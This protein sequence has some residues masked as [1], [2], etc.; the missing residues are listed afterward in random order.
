MRRSL[1]AA[2]LA[3]T[4]AIALAP[5]GPAE[6]DGPGDES[7]SSQAFSSP[8]S[9]A[10]A[11]AVKDPVEEGI[12]HQELSTSPQSE[13][14]LG[15]IRS[16]LSPTRRQ[17]AR[18]ENPAPGP[19]LESKPSSSSMPRTAIEPAADRGPGDEI[20]HAELDTTPQTGGILGSASG[21]TTAV[22]TLMTAGSD[23][24]VPSP[25]QA[26][27][28]AA[29]KDEPAHLELADVPQKTGI[30]GLYT[31]NVQAQPQETAGPAGPTGAD[32]TA[33][34][35]V[36]LAQASGEEELTHQALATAVSEKD[37]FSF[38]SAGVLVP[39]VDSTFKKFVD[40][41]GM[42]TMGARKRMSD[43]LTLS[44]TVGVGVLSGDWSIK[45]DRQ[46]ILVAAE[47]YYPGYVKE[48]GVV[49]TPEELPDENLGISYHAEA[50]AVVTSS[51]SLE[52]IDVHTD[53]YLFPVSLNAV[54]QVKQS[55]KF[56]AYVTGGLGFCTAVRDCDSK[57]V[58]EKYFQGPEYRVAI[59]RSQSVTGLLV[60]LGAG[61]SMPVYGRLTFVAEA[62]TTLYDLKAFDPVLEVS[63]TRPN[64]DW[65]PGSD[66]SQWSYEDPVRVGVYKEV[67][68]TNIQVG[69]V[70][71]F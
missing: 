7:L 17:E 15:F 46:S 37:T 30:L 45:G 23:V 48:P 56:N 24:R 12:T 9:A 18:L 44:A 43:K 42:V 10:T 63:F 38:V 47:E 11:Q 67:Y 52:R 28:T 33:Q 62:T 41:G 32:G 71:P 50:E 5:A 58:K 61:M 20:V 13:S 53:L 55:P 27:E 16:L 57:A 51:E 6:A 60:N 3:A 26:T 70:V 54:Y 39:L 59:N 36:K 49:I 34:R 68:V 35:G 22:E 1:Y 2:V 25:M 8:P 64:P 19:G 40:Y 4:L 69:F 66:L 65:Y 14:L 31:T 29:D 21:Q